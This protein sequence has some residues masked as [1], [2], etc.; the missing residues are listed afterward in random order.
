MTT[1]DEAL[2]MA[3]EWVEGWKGI[4]PSKIGLLRVLREALEQP[5]CSKCGK[6]TQQGECFYGCRQEQPAQEPYCWLGY[7]M[8]AHDEKPFEGATPL[9]KHPAPTIKQSLK[10][11][12]AQEPVAWIKE[13]ELGYIK[14]NIAIG[15]MDY[16][17]NLGLKPEPDDVAL[18]THPAP[19]QW[20]SVKDRLPEEYP[21]DSGFLKGST[22]SHLVLCFGHKGIEVGRTINR[23]WPNTM[24]NSS[25]VTHWMP[26]PEAPKE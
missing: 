21:I 7:G 26:L 13:V 16:R 9:Y 4:A 18:Y 2:K 8:Q 3:I 23:V 20:I 10:V 12:S 15:K 11:E 14:S 22:Y 5:V 25:D 6:P 24:I 17:T 1:K 19:S